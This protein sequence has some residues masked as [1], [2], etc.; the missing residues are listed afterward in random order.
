[1]YTAFNSAR[2]MMWG[3][4]GGQHGKDLINLSCDHL[5]MEQPYRNVPHIIPKDLSSVNVP[6]LG[7]S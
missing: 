5:I 2:P 3:L 7:I 6:W 1:M 4:V